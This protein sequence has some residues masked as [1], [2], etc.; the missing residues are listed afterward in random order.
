LEPIEGIVLGPE[1]GFYA[2]LIGSIVDRTIKPPDD[3][4]LFIF[5]VLAEPFGVLACGFLAKGKW[6]TVVLIYAIMLVACLSLFTQLQ[7]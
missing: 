1:A 7:K 5:G 4:T 3:T 6:R 2:A